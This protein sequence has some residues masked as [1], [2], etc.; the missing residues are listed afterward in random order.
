ML[1]VLL[2]LSTCARVKIVPDYQALLVEAV[3]EGD[4]EAGRALAEERNARIARRELDEAPIAYDELELLSRL[5]FASAGERLY[6]EEYRLCVG[7][8]VLNRVASPEFPDTLSE[9]VFQRGQFPCVDEP[10]FA[11]LR[12]S[13]ACAEAALRLL[14]GERR[15]APQVVYQS[16]WQIG[17]AFVR[18]YDRRLGYT[19]FCES[20]YPE[21]YDEESASS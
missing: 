12:P 6:S 21:L 4:A 5:I 15:L 11:D 1:P 8:M 16:S 7:E 10:E 3:T 18:F 20:V 19:Y 2:G 17:P 14:L 13:R 9:V